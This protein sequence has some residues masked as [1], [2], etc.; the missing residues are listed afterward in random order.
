MNTQAPPVFERYLAVDLHKDYVVVG[1]VDGRQQVVLPPRRLTLDA[2]P[3]W[4]GKN[5]RRTDA[6]VVEATTN[7][8]DFY[9]GAAPLVGRAVVA[10]AGKVKLIAAAQVKT[11]KVD[12]LALARLLAAGFIPEVWVPPVPVREL[13]SLLA[14]RRRLI[15]N[16]TML[17][18]RLH[19]VL[20]RHH[21]A[22]P[23]GDPFLPAQQAWWE[24]LPVSPTERLHLRHDRATLAV[25]GPQVA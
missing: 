3:A 5:L 25:L 1:G 15:K 17:Q 22:P 8:W 7:A 21:L 2:W 9:D 6:L 10:N 19:S 4:A 20:H 18:N 11:D 23:E 16:R 12:V 13:R 14:H 24:A